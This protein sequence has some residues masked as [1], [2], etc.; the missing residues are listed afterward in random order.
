MNPPPTR[1]DP[2]QRDNPPRN[3]PSR[4]VP[5]PRSGPF[6]LLGSKTLPTGFLGSSRRGLFPAQNPAFQH[7][8]FGFDLIRVNDGDSVTVRPRP[9]AKRFLEGG[10]GVARE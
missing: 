8:T 7:G 6:T 9:P 1:D 5:G 10:E 4:T 2:T 3:R